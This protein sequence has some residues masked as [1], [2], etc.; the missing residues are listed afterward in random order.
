MV[1]FVNP[2]STTR[3]PGFNVF[4]ENIQCI[5]LDAGANVA[6]PR[7]S[8]S[9]FKLTRTEFDVDGTLVTELEDWIDALDRE[10]DPLKNFILASGGRSA[11]TLHVARNMAR[12]AERRVVP[13]IVDN[14]ADASVGKY[15]N[16]LSD[17]LFTAA[18]YAA[19]F[20]GKP[21]R[22]YKKPN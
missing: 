13:L 16:R 12:S 14:L 7:G 22:V 2:F 20:E 8:A 21:E 1:R 9:Q 11:S 15:L 3:V 10:L 4:D 19:K 5:L 18:R 17:Y 6:T